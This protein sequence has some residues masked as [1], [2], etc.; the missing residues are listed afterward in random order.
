MFKMRGGE[1][2]LVEAKGFA[3]VTSTENSQSIPETLQHE[4]YVQFLKRVKKK[5]L[6]G[7]SAP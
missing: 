7:A 4:H 5:K 2:W 1:A 6:C 3:G